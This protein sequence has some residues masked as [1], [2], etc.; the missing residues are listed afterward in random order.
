MAEPR[1]FTDAWARLS[2]QSAHCFALVWETEHLRKLNQS[3]LAF[4][5]S[6]ARPGRAW[7]GFTLL[8]PLLGERHVQYIR[9][10]FACICSRAKCAIASSTS[11][12]LAFIAS[13]P[14]HIS[15]ALAWSLGTGDHMCSVLHVFAVAKVHNCVRIDKLTPVACY[16]FLACAMRLRPDRRALL[17]LHAGE[18]H[19]ARSVCPALLQ[20]WSLVMAPG[21]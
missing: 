4:L 8:I 15:A 19:W 3:L 20:C 11:S 2:A 9:S 14:A 1:D 21:P 17:G 12:L 10:V 13:P 6:T 18:L 7:G 5:A 16:A